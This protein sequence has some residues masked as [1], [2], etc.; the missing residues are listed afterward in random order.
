MTE[1]IACLSSGEATRKHV[2]KLIDGETWDRVFLITNKTNMA[3]FSDSIEKNKLNIE[4]IVVDNEQF[5]PELIE[6]IRD[7]LKDKIIGTEVALNLI[8]GTGKDNM[9]ILSALLKLGFGI[10]LVALTKD[11]VREV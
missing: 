5:L 11:G 2:A 1:L 4:F 9:A 6:E 3:E 10:R 7:I 8:S